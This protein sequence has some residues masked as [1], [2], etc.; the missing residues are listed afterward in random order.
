MFRMSVMKRAGL[1]FTWGVAATEWGGRER[2]GL[3]IWGDPFP[4]HVS[5]ISWSKYPYL[6]VA[7]AVVG[8]T[9]VFS[10]FS[11]RELK[12]AR[13]SHTKPEAGNGIAVEPG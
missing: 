3:P 1:L 5:D 6:V 11:F 9:V 8:I 10:F 4:S 2:E 7:V 13:T 12:P